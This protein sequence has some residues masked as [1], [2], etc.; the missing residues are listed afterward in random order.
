M[1]R[2]GPDQPVI[3]DR[4]ELLD[5][6]VGWC[7][8][9]TDRDGNAGVAACSSRMDVV[10]P[11]FAGHVAPFLVGRDARAV[12]DF[13]DG[14]ERFKSS[15]KLGLPFR[16][17]VAA[18][19]AACLDLV[20]KLADQNVADLLGGRR[21]GT[22]DL[23]LSHTGRETTPQE[24]VDLFAPRLAATG[25]RAIKYKVGGRMSRNADAAP[26]RTEAVTA[27]LAKAFPA[28]ERWADANGSYDA[29]HAIEVGR[30]LNANGVA[31]FEEP[32]PFDE[33]EQTRQVAD[34]LDMTVAGGEQ[35]TSF[36]R[37]R[38]QIEHRAVDLL[39]P[40]VNYCGGLVR[41]LRVATLANDHG[42]PVAPHSPKSGPEGAILL[43]AASLARD[44]AAFHEWSVHPPRSTDW[45]SPAL[46]PVDG[47]IDVPSGAG[48]GVTID[49]DRLAGAK[50]V[51]RRG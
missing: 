18:A 17:C 34:A 41:F 16:V 22:I 39:Q 21:R 19:E 8:R 32:C 40:D 38:W 7:C 35:D 36:A 15:Y 48:L 3:V 30:M 5:L 31:V 23:Y 49:P 11:I 50:V 46:L 42:L 28:V 10:W 6:G 25:C 43:H 51:V 1:T 14:V 37:F 45:H 2:L 12:E 4:I 13:V 33:Y 20:G 29:D 9:V 26:G 47:G 44:V 24:E 27:A